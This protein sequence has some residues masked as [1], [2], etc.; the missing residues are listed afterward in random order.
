MRRARKGAW[1][2]AS[3]LLLA[4]ASGAAAAGSGNSA[5]AAGGTPMP[6]GMV[7]VFAAECK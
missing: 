7:T 3:M 2:R 4:L 5:A 6:G 1:I